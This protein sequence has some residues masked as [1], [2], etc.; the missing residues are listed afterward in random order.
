VPKLTLRTV[1]LGLQCQSSIRGRRRRLE[2]RGTSEQR[3]YTQYADIPRSF[4]FGRA[5]SLGAWEDDGSLGS[6]PASMVSNWHRNDRGSLVVGED[7]EGKKGRRTVRV[8]KPRTHGIQ[9]G[10]T[11]LLYRPDAGVLM[12]RGPVAAG[13]IRR[14]SAS[15]QAWE[16]LLVY[17]ARAKGRPQVLW[18]TLT[19]QVAGERWSSA[20]RALVFTPAGVDGA[21][22]DVT[23][24]TD[25]QRVREV[26]RNGRWVAHRAK[27]GLLTFRTRCNQPVT[28]AFD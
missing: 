22:S 13:K 24:F 3:L 2:G 25:G 10:C 7:T 27:G 4:G 12:E 9:P 11:Y 17:V 21:L 20:K 8:K 28:V 5:D 23:V 6:D 19:D 26:R 18:A 14:L 1:S 15:L 16:P